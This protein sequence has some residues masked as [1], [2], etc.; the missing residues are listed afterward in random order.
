ME[1]ITVRCG[2]CGAQFTVPASMA[3]KQARCSCGHSVTIPA[4]GAGPVAGEGPEGARW[5]YSE[6]GEAR[7]PLSLEQMRAKIRRGELQPEQKVFSDALG[8][9]TALA[10][11]AELRPASGNVPAEEGWYI[12][13]D[14]K[15]YGPY[16]AE[17]VEEMVKKGQAE[18][19]SVVW[20]PSL[21]QWRPLGDVARFE[22]A[23][24]EAPGAQEE[25]VE[26][27]WYYQREGERIGPLTLEQMVAAADEGKVRGT[28]R[29]WSNRM[30]GWRDA[31]AVPELAD[32]VRRAAS[33]KRELWYYRSR[34]GE[35]GGP[36]SFQEICGLVEQR[37]IRSGDSVF[38][39]GTGEW[40]EV[41]DVPELAGALA[42]A[43]VG[44]GKAD[45]AAAEWYFR[46]DGK[47]RG[48]VTERYL[49]ELAARGKLEADDLVWHS[50]FNRWQRL[51]EVPQFA[52]YVDASSA[53]PG[54]VGPAPGSHVS[55]LAAR[56]A[57]VTR[58]TQ[59]RRAVGFAVL[60]LLIASLAAVAFLVYR[61]SDE[62]NDTDRKPPPFVVPR[63][64]FAFVMTWLELFL[65]DTAGL[66]QVDRDV[67][68]QKLEMFYVDGY[69][70]AYGADVKARLTAAWDERGPESIQIEEVAC[71]IRRS[72][73]SEHFCY[74]VPLKAASVSVQAMAP[75]E[76]GRLETVQKSFARDDFRA[77][78][79]F[80]ITSAGE[81]VHPSAFALVEER[82]GAL[83][84]VALGR[85]AHVGTKTPGV[86][87][88]CVTGFKSTTMREEDSLLRLGVSPLGGID[89]NGWDAY[90]E[91]MSVDSG[92]V[93]ISVMRRRL[94]ALKRGIPA[95][96]L[97]EMAESGILWDEVV[98]AYGSPQ[99]SVGI[100]MRSAGIHVETA[101]QAG[102]A[103]YSALDGHY[104][105]RFGLAVDPVSGEVVGYLFGR[106][107]SGAVRE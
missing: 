88:E 24:K 23:L 16:A 102:G 44:L 99:T 40:K 73:D 30:Q 55:E 25:S 71:E 57:P 70:D 60:L 2:E 104:Y 20:H 45:R 35:V 42:A 8:A 28:D 49:A 5:Y 38:S 67:L 53:G 56:P 1:N 85:L 18:P 95:R 103:L 86:H 82:D 94:T 93:P 48:P 62:G 68:R 90:G 76:G 63:E 17:R 83:K 29:A 11:V 61:S 14:G 9:W 64:P 75:G 22:S 100:D 74:H 77:L 36:V 50:S 3:G 89:E 34:A 58:P 105:G 12:G 41:R 65:T 51:C 33:R 4:P 39:K 79:C 19:D 87:V 43:A 32:A 72:A 26:E 31:Q 27:L 80:R 106:P 21:G 46:A 91:L 7:G 10:G 69:M 98:Q 47:E 92:L 84:L 97:L 13:I 15:S 81:A 37:K 54:P 52:P 96:C 6:G 78:R 101:S 107:A 59:R 66:T